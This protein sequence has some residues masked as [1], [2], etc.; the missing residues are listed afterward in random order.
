[1]LGKGVVVILD[2]CL[3]KMSTTP[4]PSIKTYGKSIKSVVGSIK[5]IK[6]APGAKIKDFRFSLNSAP[7]Q[8]AA[9]ILDF[10]LFMLPTTLFMFFFMLFYA[11]FMV[12]YA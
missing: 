12:F 7:D 3:S 10:M 4:L 1:M 6:P 5:S 8:F 9:R 2:S 11:F